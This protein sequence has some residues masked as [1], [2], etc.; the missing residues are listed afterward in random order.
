MKCG[1][2][3]GLTTRRRRDQAPWTQ[4]LP[5][6]CQFRCVLQ[7]WPTYASDTITN[8]NPSTR[9]RSTTNAIRLKYTAC[10]FCSR[11]SRS[12]QCKST[13]TLERQQT[14]FSYFLMTQ[15]SE[16]V[17]GQSL[18]A[19]LRNCMVPESAGT[20][21]RGGQYSQC[22][23]LGV[24]AITALAGARARLVC[25]ARH[26]IMDASRGGVGRVAGLSQRARVSA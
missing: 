9:I 8:R 2:S 13:A 4:M 26:A 11:F 20:R 25:S 18:T 5:R 6:W 24:A 16:G 23:V 21:K 17:A 7:A 15:V 12:E 1:T 3:L 19:S 14:A 22:R 10:A